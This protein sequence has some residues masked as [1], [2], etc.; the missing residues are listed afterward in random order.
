MGEAAEESNRRTCE[1]L[2]R[3]TM[4]KGLWHES[5]N[6]FLFPASR[7]RIDQAVALTFSSFWMLSSAIGVLLLRTVAVT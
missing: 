4:K 7:F 1:I 5:H 2:A 3:G 6:P